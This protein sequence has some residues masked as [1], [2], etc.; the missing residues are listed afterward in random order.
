MPSA[1]PY[2]PDLESLREHPVPSWYED[3]KLGIFIHWTLASI[4]AF[5]PRD[6]EINELIRKR[7]DDFMLLSPYAEWYE[8]ALRF[9]DSPSAR[10]HRQRYGDRPYTAFQFDWEAALAQWDAAAWAERFRR[11]GARYVVLVA[12]H[13]DGYCLWPSEVANP[14][15]PGWRSK[16]DVVGELAAAVRGAGLRFGVYYSGGIDWSFNPKPVRTLVDLMASVPR[17]PYPD[18]AEAQVRELVR[19][20]E[21][22]VLWNDIAW[23][24]PQARLNQ[25]FADYYAAVPDGLVND[26]WLCDGWRLRSLRIQP[27]R[28]LADALVKRAVR[29]GRALTTPPAPPHYDVR[30]PEY[31]VFDAI[32]TRKWECVRGMDKSFGYNRQSREADFIGEAELVHGFVDIVSKNGNLL[33]NVGPRGEDAAIPELQIQRLDAL[34]RWLDQNGEAIYG[35]RPWRRAAGATSEGLGVRFTARGDD[36]FAIVL[37]TPNQR[38]LTL[39]DVRARPGAVVRRLGGDRLAWNQ[40]GPDL[41]VE[42]DAPLPSAPAH[43][44]CIPQ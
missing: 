2:G 20:V 1:P 40:M 37:D 22:E 27:L 5:A 33:L 6:Y 3:A 13:H 7:Y 35:T 44:F 38:Q 25:L 12:K 8:N 39:C 41:R 10:F 32:R 30:T 31:A 21:P 42:L 26:R 17:G 4:P 43:A 18:Y 23:P 24:T 29:A 19:R 36:V 16:R 14:R 28:A 34:G 15:R 9:P 11:A